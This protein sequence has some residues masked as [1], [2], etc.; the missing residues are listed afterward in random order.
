MKHATAMSRLADVCDGLDR[1]AEW[2]DTSVTG[3]FVFGASL[4]AEVD[5]DYVEVAFVVVEPPEVV[6]WMSRPAHLEALAAM[7]RFTKL[8]LSWRWRPAEWPAWNHEIERAVRVWSA[9][10]GRD[11]SALDALAVGQSSIT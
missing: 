1:A 5:P 10:G 8:P 7:L 9:A 11:Q 3:A 6:P 4:D 2:P